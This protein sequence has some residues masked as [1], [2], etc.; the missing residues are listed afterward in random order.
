MQ[1]NCKNSELKFYACHFFACLLLFDEKLREVARGQ[2]VERFFVGISHTYKAFFYLWEDYYLAYK[3][4]THATNLSNIAK[5]TSGLLAT[6]WFLYGNQEPQLFSAYQPW[7][8]G[9]NPLELLLEKPSSLDF[10]I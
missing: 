10:R 1:S 4:Q 5:V 6:F 9:N 7:K 8:V 2:N 3:T